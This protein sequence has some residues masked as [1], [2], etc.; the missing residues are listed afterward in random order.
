MAVYL[1]KMAA[2]M[3]GSNLI[4]TNKAT[5]ENMQCHDTHSDLSLTVYC[6]NQPD[7]FLA[8]PNL[9]TVF[10][11]NSAA[12]GLCVA[13]TRLIASKPI[14]T[15]SLKRSAILNEKGYW[16]RI[17]VVPSMLLFCSSERKQDNSPQRQLAPKA[18]PQDIMMIMVWNNW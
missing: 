14:D 11:Y 3:V 17:R 2:T 9:L 1:S 5:F 6:Q 7:T 12:S 10:W 8:P 15:T 16:Q 13:C 4:Y 18:T